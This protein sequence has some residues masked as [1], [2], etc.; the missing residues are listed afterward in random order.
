MR[1]NSYLYRVQRK[2]KAFVSF[3]A[4]FHSSF[5]VDTTRLYSAGCFQRLLLRFS[6]P[7]RFLLKPLFLLFPH[8]QQHRPTALLFVKHVCQFCR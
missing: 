7:R 6:F 2:N 3:P 4:A 1:C 5:I 8:I